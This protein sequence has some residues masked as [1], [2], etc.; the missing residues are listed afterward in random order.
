MLQRRDFTALPSRVELL[1]T[2][3]IEGAYTKALSL[4]EA[5]LASWKNAADRGGC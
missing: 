2:Y 4:L 5:K 1:A 3:Q